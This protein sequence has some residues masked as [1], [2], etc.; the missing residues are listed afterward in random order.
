MP[1]W[2]GNFVWAMN[3]AKYDALP[4]HPIASAHR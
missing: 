2:T 4:A 3:K 1:F